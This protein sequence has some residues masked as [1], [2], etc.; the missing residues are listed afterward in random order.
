M[1]EPN[2]PPLPGPFRTPSFGEEAVFDAYREALKL[3]LSAAS[4]AAEKIATGALG[5][6]TAYGALIGL[7]QAEDSP[8]P[9]VVGLPFAGLAAAVFFALRAISVGIPVS[10]PTRV[11]EV[12]GALEKV[13]ST[14]Q[15]RLDVATALLALS[16]IAAGAAVWLTYR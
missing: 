11:D 9:I 6:A 13:I 3:A 14:K 12:A 7:V 1:P 10:A 2:L 16:I 8:A 5:L 15:F 4:S